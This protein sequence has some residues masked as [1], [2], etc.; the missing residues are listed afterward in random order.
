MERKEYKRVI[1]KAENYR[2]CIDEKSTKVSPILNPKSLG[3]L[4][5]FVDIRRQVVSKFLKGK[6][7]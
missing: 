3:R 2:V 1:I 5:S 4:V 7:A 6:W